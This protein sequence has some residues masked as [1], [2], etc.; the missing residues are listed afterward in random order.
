MAIT[1][2]DKAKQAALGRIC[3][4]PSVTVLLNELLYCQVSTTY[5]DDDLVFLNLHEH[6]FLAILVNSLALSFE[7]HLVSHIIGHVVNEICQLL[8]EWVVLNGIV[9]ERVLGDVCVVLQLHDYVMQSLDLAIA[10]LQVLE[11]LNRGLLCLLALLFDFEEVVRADL[12]VVLVLVLG[13]LEAVIGRFDLQ[14]LGLQVLLATK[15][16]LHRVDLAVQLQVLVSQGLNHDVL[17]TLFVEELVELG[18]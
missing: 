10:V 17:V 12:E 3:T 1:A 5:P 11:E 15:E 6:A 18:I 8:V 16:L 13:L 2:I 14:K 4:A 7:P 9:D